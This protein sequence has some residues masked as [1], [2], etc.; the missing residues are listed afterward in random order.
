MPFKFLKLC[1]QILE[2]IK[3]LGFTIPSPIQE[4]AIPEIANR[5]D[6]HACAKTGSGKTAAYLLPV[7][8]RL[9]ETISSRGKFA[10]PKVLILVPTRELALQVADEAMKFS[11]HIPQI[12][13]VC[14]YG[15]VPYPQQIRQLRSPYDILV[16]TPGRLIDHLEQNRVNLSSIDVLILDEADRMLDMGFIGPVEQIAQQTPKN[17]QTLLFSA[18]MSKNVIRLSRNL[19]NKPVEIN[20]APEKTSHENIEQRLYFT[21]SLDHKC[22]VLHHLLNDPEINQAIVFTATKRFADQLVDILYKSGFSAAALHGDLNQRQRTRTLNKLR[23]GEIRFLV[24]TDVAARGIDIQSITHVI[25]FDLPAAVE[26]YVHRIGRTGRAGAKG[27]ALSF[28]FAS[29]RQLIGGIEK[30][31]G[32]KITL[33]Q[34][35]DEEL[36]SVPTNI[37][38]P[39][40]RSREGRFNDRG[41]GESRNGPRRNDRPPRNDRRP[42]T[43]ASRDE[44]RPPREERVPRD[45]SKPRNENR[46]PRSDR[47]PPREERRFSRGDRRPPRDESRPPR[48]FAEKEASKSNSS[49]TSSGKRGGPFGNIRNSIPNRRLPQKTG[50]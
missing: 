32:H 13:T 23:D 3:E 10:G 44:S 2:V 24:A 25:N 27:I 43:E 37:V 39:R 28:A 29:D 47:R 31:L 18:T 46:P 45:D 4:K 12:K 1:P 49:P 5:S 33:H 19:L 38:P 9:V 11:K 36:S 6:I 7:L 42:R 14:V 34:V 35:T 50:G 17:R 48:S 26:D 41:G 15:G 30:F 8:N 21:K 22:R 40:S 20:I 16:A